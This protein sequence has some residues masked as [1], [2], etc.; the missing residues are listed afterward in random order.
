MPKVQK[1]YMFSHDLDWFF[2]YG[3]KLIHCASNGCLLPDKVNDNQLLRATQDIIS[4]LPD[5]F[6]DEEIIRNQVYV[7]TYVNQYPEGLRRLLPF[8]EDEITNI[9][10][11]SFIAMAKKGF[12]SYDHVYDLKDNQ[13]ILVAYPPLVP[14]Y[15]HVLVQQH[16]LL[17]DKLSDLIHSLDVKFDDKRTSLISIY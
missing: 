8:E 12:W 4:L 5:I 3:D 17:K 11:S 13:Y 7:D 9:H 16:P 6:T 10:L 14:D 15:S 2:K 1:S